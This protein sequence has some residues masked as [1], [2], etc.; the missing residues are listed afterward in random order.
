MAD[1]DLQDGS[2]FV[3]T[4]ASNSYQILTNQ[5]TRSVYMLDVLAKIQALSET[6]KE[7]PQWLM[8]EVFELRSEVEDSQS[9]E[10]L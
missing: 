5:L 7:V 6:D 3:S 4:Y 1:D 9:E 8:M 10:E 2:T